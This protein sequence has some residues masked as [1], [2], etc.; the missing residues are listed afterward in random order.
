MKP[1]QRIKKLHDLVAALN[2]AIQEASKVDLKVT[3]SI[4][5]VFQ[6][7]KPFAIPEIKINIYKWYR[8]WK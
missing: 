8:G 6:A 5:Q 4:G 3:V 7:E 1:D 2:T